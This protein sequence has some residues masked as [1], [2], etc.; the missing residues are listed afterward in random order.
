MHSNVAI[1]VLTSH[2]RVNSKAI[3]RATRTSFYHF[4][5]GA[6]KDSETPGSNIHNRTN[7]IYKIHNKTIKIYYKKNINILSKNVK[8]TGCLKISVTTNFTLLI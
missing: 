2:W 6:P 8:Y 5:L 4:L 3:Q 7:N 1:Y